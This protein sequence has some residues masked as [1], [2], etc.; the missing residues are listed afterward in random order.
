M[1]PKIIHYCWLSNDPI[2]KDL[3]KYMKSWKEKLYDYEF[4]LWDLN[5]FDLNRSLWVKQAFE[6]KK[7]AFAADYIRLYA[8]YNYGGIYMD[9]DVEVIKSFNDLLRN[10]YI[11]G[12]EAAKGL[13]AGVFGAP[14]KAPWVKEVLEYYTSKEFALPNGLYNDTPLPIIMDE[15]LNADYI[16]NKKIVPLPTD[17]LTAKSYKTG[18]I[19]ITPNTYTIHHFAGSWKS[20]DEK[21]KIIIARIIGTKLTHILGNAR[22]CIIGKK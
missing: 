13:E 8:V 2:P 4:I 1:I 18:K 14:K 21:M 16:T 7:Y 17:F 12:Y 20:W 9:M 19:T 22:R 10:D 15:V 3:K 11:L 6:A 5:R